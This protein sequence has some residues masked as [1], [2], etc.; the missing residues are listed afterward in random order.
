MADTKPVQLQ[1]N[2][3]G[4]WKNVCNFDAANVAA[5]DKVTDAAEALQQID[6]SLKFRIATRDGLNEALMHLV[7]GEWKNAR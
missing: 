2:N 5:A 3:T 6:P 4:A 7:K 1:V